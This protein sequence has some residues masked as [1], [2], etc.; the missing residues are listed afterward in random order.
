MVTGKCL[1]DF[2]KMYLIA[3]KAF[4]NKQKVNVMQTFSNDTFMTDLQSNYKF[5]TLSFKV[6]K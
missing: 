5:E 4:Y 1:S 2:R 6:F 3:M